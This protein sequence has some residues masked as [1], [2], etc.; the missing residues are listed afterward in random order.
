MTDTPTPDTPAKPTLRARAIAARRMYSTEERLFATI[1]VCERALPLLL[2]TEGVIGL[3]HPFREELDPGPLVERL[4]EAGR[5]LALP[6]VLSRREPLVFRRWKPGD[7]L[8]NGQMTIPEPPKDAPEV[9]P[10][11]LIAPP[12]AFDRRC[13]RIG[14]GAGFYDRTIPVLRARHEVTTI[15]YAFAVQE[16]EHVPNEAH[17]VPLDA[18]VTDNDV[19]RGGAA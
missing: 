5:E 16:V 19:F 7:P 8:V 13:Y 18:I 9:H 14:Y 2:A 11:V 10:D 12:V 6:C 17:D 4:V 3:Y 1:A 15:G